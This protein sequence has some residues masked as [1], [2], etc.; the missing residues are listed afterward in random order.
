MRVVTLVGFRGIDDIE[1][2]EVNIPWFRKNKTHPRPAPFPSRWEEV[3]VV[4]ERPMPAHFQE[5]WELATPY[6]P[7]A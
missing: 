3:A 6:I 4:V 1:K 2:I 7:V 5:G